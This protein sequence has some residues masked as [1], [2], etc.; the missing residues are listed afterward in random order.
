MKKID[1]R[2]VHFTKLC[3]GKKRLSLFDL[4]ICSVA[5]KNLKGEHKKYWTKDCENTLKNITSIIEYLNS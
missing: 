1:F 4:V 3:E 2:K 5:L